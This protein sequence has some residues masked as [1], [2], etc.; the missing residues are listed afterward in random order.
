MLF[1]EIIAVDCHVNVSCVGKMCG[2]CQSKWYV[3]LP[4]CL[5]S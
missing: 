4:V 3:E 2:A 1:K 5:R